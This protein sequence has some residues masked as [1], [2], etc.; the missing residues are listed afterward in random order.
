MTDRAVAIWWLRWPFPDEGL[1]NYSAQIRSMTGAGQNQASVWVC[2]CVLVLSSSTLISKEGITMCGYR[3]IIPQVGFAR[4]CPFRCDRILRHGVGSD[5]SRYWLLVYRKRVNSTNTLFCMICPR[6]R[7]AP[8][9][10]ATD[11][12]L[13]ANNP[14]ASHTWVFRSWQYRMYYAAAH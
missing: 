6:C 8:R 14:N 12:L 7:S 3:T 1:S 4:P 2:S 11:S 10:N 9:S 5:K 13:A